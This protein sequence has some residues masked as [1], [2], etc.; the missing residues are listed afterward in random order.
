MQFEQIAINDHADF[1]LMKIFSGDWKKDTVVAKGI[2]KVNPSTSKHKYNKIENTAMLRFNYHIF[3]S[4][5]LELISYID[6]P[7]FL[8]FVNYGAISHFGTHVKSIDDYCTVLHDQKF[9]VLQNV[10]T[11][12]H[13]SPDVLPYRRYHYVIY[14][15]QNLHFRIKLIE[16]I[17]ASDA[18]IELE[19]IY[20][21]L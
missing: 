15:H 20:D 4:K 1:P 16:R 10:I 8:N 5:E 14:G 9:M 7:N 12:S 19:K 21:I 13:Q 2:L 11:Q 17:D 6:G 18:D 3:P